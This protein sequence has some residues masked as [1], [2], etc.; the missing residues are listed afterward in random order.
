MVDIAPNQTIYLNNVNE[1]VKKEELKKA[2]H[3]CFSQFGKILDVVSLKT[4]RLRGQA[5]VVFE[6]VTA[7]TNALRQMQ[8]FPLYDKPLRIAYAR[9]KSDVVAKADGSFVLREK[10]RDKRKAEDREREKAAHGKK[11]QA[12]AAAAAA[13]APPPVNTDKSQAPPHNILFVQNLPEAT[14]AA[15][16]TKLFQQFPGFREVRMVEAKPGI[17]FVEFENDMQSS[18]AMAGLQNFKVTPQHP[19]QITFGKK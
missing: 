3:A 11:R 9:G 6:D 17:A 15:M 13:G 18:V 10:N 2:I 5:W 1:K 16:L 8:G 4:F 19:M 12:T 7:A 14:N